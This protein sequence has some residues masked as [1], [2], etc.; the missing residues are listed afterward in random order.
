MEKK[1]EEYVKY[2]EKWKKLGKHK[3]RN[4]RRKMVKKES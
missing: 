2:Y 3:T 4:K 1:K